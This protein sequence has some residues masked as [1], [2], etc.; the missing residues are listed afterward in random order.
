M[1]L[2][3]RKEEKRKEME[4]ISS[5]K[6]DDDEVFSL[7]YYLSEEK[8]YGIGKSISNYDVLL[9]KK[10]KNHIVDAVYN[11]LP[12]KDQS[13]AISFIKKL[14]KNTV[15]PISLNELLLED[16]YMVIN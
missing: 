11:R 8:E 10:I 16:I 15:T 9:I 14:S 3:M 5:V 6:V 12:Y 4:L 13:D 7:E 1:K 2:E